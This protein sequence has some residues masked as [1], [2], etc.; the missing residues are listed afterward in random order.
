MVELVEMPRRKNVVA[1]PEP[2]PSEGERRAAEIAAMEEKFKADRDEMVALNNAWHE[3][4]KPAC[5]SIDTVRHFAMRVVAARGHL[6]AS[7]QHAAGF[8]ERVLALIGSGPPYDL[9][10]VANQVNNDPIGGSAARAVGYLERWLAVEEPR[11]KT[12]V[13]SARKLATEAPDSGPL[14]ADLGEICATLD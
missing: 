13:E 12:A 6:R 11:F 2:P 3:S 7:Q 14:L 10:L 5:E 4:R 9:S 1:P 8:D